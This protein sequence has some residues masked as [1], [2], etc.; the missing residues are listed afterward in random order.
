MTENTQSPVP[1]RRI[2]TVT[3]YDAKRQQ[4]MTT[5][6]LSKALTYTANGESVLIV[7]PNRHVHESMS[8]RLQGFLG[9]INRSNIK[10]IHHD[11]SQE[12]VEN[13]SAIIVDDYPF[14]PIVDMNGLIARNPTVDFHLGRADD[15]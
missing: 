12:D 3:Y 10:I 13:A 1:K 14:G 6:L 5:L 4:G 8:H 15:V 9:P 2:R 11:P 7:A